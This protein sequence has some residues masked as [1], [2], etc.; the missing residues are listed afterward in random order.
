MISE[1]AM[2]I[3]VIS[4][5][6]LGVLCTFSICTDSQPVAEWLLE[7]YHPICDQVGLL[8]VAILLKKVT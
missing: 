3:K 5:V 7:L 1:I 6:A 2:S 4:D 8:G